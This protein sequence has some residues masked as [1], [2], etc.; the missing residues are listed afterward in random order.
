MA[1][2]I[3]FVMDILVSV[4][5]TSFTQP[6]PDAELVGFVKSVTPKDHFQDD[7]EE[8]QPWYRR[9]VPLGIVCLVLVVAL[10][11]VFA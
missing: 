7:S 4:I 5:V 2:G 6:K 8:N 10:N 3:A 9:T 1:A 11:V